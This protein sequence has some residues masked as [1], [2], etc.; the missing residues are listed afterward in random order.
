[1]NSTVL[2]SGSWGTAL[3]IL[4]GKKGFPVKLW[5]LPD[6]AA[7]LVRD[8]EN[9]RYLPG[10]PLPNTISPISDLDQALSDAEVVVVAV[11]S[12]AVRQVASQLAGRLDARALLINAGKGLESDTGLRGSEVLTQEL[13]EQIGCGIVVL[14]G[15]NLA[16]E[17][18]SGVP[19]ATVVAGCDADRVVRAQELF[20]CPTLRVYRNPDIVGVELGGAL[21]NVLA[22]GA[23][24]SD[25]LGYGDNTKATLAT[26][27]L[28][29][30]TRLGVALGADA[31]TFSGLSGFGDLM[32]TCASRLS[33]NLRLGQMLG[34][35]KSVEDSL[36]ALGQVAEGMPTCKAAYSLSKKLGIDAP[37]TEQIHAVLFENKLPKQAVH[38]LMTRQYKEEYA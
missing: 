33:R 10:A 9:V 22:I 32:A 21:K 28:V 36:A 24:I 18:A 20:S 4:L 2:G 6:E 17:L 15:P 23:G 7:V 35:G 37:I 14:S 34:Q 12:A 38:D 8:R 27:G 13:G 16:V 25:G 1:M 26:R 31:R 29:E 19:T 30:M 3:A 5:G 11:P